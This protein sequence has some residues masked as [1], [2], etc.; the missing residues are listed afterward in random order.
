MER[1][2]DR[3]FAKIDAAN[4]RILWMTGLNLALTMAVL[5]LLLRAGG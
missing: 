4:R 2:M 5:F 3:R 1:E